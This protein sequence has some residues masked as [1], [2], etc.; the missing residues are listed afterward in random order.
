[1]RIKKYLDATRNKY[2]ELQSLLT[3]TQDGTPEYNRIRNEIL[4]TYQ[5]NDEKYGK[6][7]C[8]YDELTKK[9]SHIKQ[10]VMEYDSCI[11]DS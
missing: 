3:R 5:Q 11:S 10:L 7:K 9:L 6:T 4:T 8:R 1:L 2:V